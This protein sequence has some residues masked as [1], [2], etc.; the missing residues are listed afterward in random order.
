V[1]EVADIF[2]TAA[3]KPMNDN[4]VY[5]VGDDI[6]DMADFIAEVRSRSTW[7]RD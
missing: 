2:V 5:T 7:R 6:V 1:R 3:R 4:L